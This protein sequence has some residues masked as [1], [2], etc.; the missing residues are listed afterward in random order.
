MTDPIDT[1]FEQRFGSIGKRPVQ[2]A[3]SPL[4]HR[5]AGTPQGT[6]PAPARLAPPRFEQWGDAALMALSRDTRA[7]ITEG[8]DGPVGDWT[9]SRVHALLLYYLARNIN[10]PDP[11]VVFPLQQPPRVLEI[12]VRHGVTTL[13]LL[14]AMAETGGTLHSVEIDEQWAKAATKEVER[15]GLQAQWRLNV[16]SS[17]AFAASYSDSVEFDLIWIDGDHGLEQVTKDV[18]NFAPMVRRGGILALHDY[19]SQPW[20]CDPPVCPPFPSYAS[21]PVEKL[22]ASGEWEVF[23][24]PFSYGVALCRKL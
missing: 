9:D 14:H 15:A 22:R 4:A 17:D 11:R 6:I 7:W 21:V 20:P 13:A 12:G 23:V 3:G 18:D 8:P 1:M 19:Y 5:G 24:V 2:G 10:A 16:C